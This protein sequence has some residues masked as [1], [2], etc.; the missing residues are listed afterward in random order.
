MSWRRFL[1]RKHW[2]L[3]RRLEIASYLETETADNI[4][5]GM[6]PS[7]AASAAR[8]TFGNPT[9]IREEI[10]RMNTVSWLESIAQ[11]LRY[12]ARLLA[13][14][15]GFTVVAVVSL[16]LGIG[17]N[18][19]IFQLIDAVRLRSLPVQNPH[20]LAEIKIV[21]GNGGMGMND[22]YG[23]LT[24]PM[25]EEIRRSHP[26]FSGVFAWS[27]YQK[28][29][30][31]G[32]DAD[33]VN[34]LIVT[35]DA[36]R[37]LGVQPWRGRSIGPD[38]E[39][40]CPDSTVMVSHAYWQSKL[41]SRELDANTKLIVDGVPAQVVGV[42]PPSFFGLAVGES[43]D[44]VVPFCQPQQLMRNLFDVTVMGRLR[45]GVS[46][47]QA[48]AQL[49]G[50]SP[51]IMAATEITGY[52]AKVISQYLQFKLAAQ[53][54]A[55]GVSYLRDSYDSSLQLLLGI[56]GLVL[57]I[58]CANL[59]NLMFARASVRER[60]IAVRLALGAGRVRLLRQLIVESSLLA[61]IGAALGVGLAQVL[62]RV[63]VRALS[64]EDS[65]VTLSTG[66]DLPVLAF[67]ALIAMLTCLIFGMV[68]ALRASG[69]DPG[70]AIRAGG[71]GMTASRERFSMQR[72]MVVFQISVSLV[73]LFS[74]LLFV[75]SFHNLLTFD[76]GMREK[77][78][79]MAF[80]GFQN[81]HV[82]KDH[83]EEFTHELVEEIRSIPGVQNAASTTNTPLMGNSWGHGVTVRG[84]E[85]A[86][87]FTWV[88]PGYFDTMGIRLLSGRD[89]SPNDTNASARVA[90]VNQTFVREY[91]SGV[92]PI[93]QT[94]RTHAE[95]S[96]PSTVYE[97]V[98]TIPDTKYNDLRGDTPPMA[99]APA[100]QFPNPRPWTA[101][102]IHS[103]LSAAT[104]A[105]SVKRRIA[106]K[107]PEII[108][109]CRSFE[110]RIQDGLVR[111]RMMAMLSG[112]FGVLAAVL[113]T[114]GLYGVISYVVTR[115]RN[116]IGI[117]IAIGAGR[118]QV[119]GMVMM[120]AAL[121]L[122]C[123]VVI[124]IVLALAAGRGA[125]SLLFDLKPYD[126][127]T[128][129]SAIVL[130]AV[131]GAVATLLPAMRASKLDPSEALRCD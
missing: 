25:W 128:L 93:G 72:M 126:P 94:V 101:I 55:T 8:R 85:G 83:M 33:P 124:G 99:I 96:Y 11:D 32:G 98:G 6:T 62:S 46:L 13:K 16:A 48:S 57:L 105:E 30:G 35:G 103:N 44:I 123:G 131:I 119:V 120:E 77:G 118:G 24:R 9:L 66:T 80:V 81:A 5:R 65:A 42:T 21:G 10:Y 89:F 14:S 102:M 1:K 63:L 22:A 19:A 56:T 110:S 86:S 41:G 75:R 59:A 34:A 100:S 26:S 112:F 15:P 122:A 115:R 2:D 51:G 108:V 114:V 68:P 53:S 82:A 73:L 95:P 7:E 38:D 91:L 40:A 50:M 45:P 121:L 84:A 127:L 104:A 54:A 29:V 36:F 70:S 88:S 90:V 106:S 31:E 43:F 17:A 3:E 129:G 111:E 23:E 69:A 74:A 125:G 39:H 76:P 117:R 4:A 92:N 113:A 20:E 58:A 64:T 67:A 109:G 97:I 47:P 116:E 18:T 52:D 87:K 130:L 37:T 12:G 27:K 107:H 78:I 71:R 49:T 28:I 61:A 79:T 60:E